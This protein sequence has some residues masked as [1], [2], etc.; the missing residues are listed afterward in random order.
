MSTMSCRLVAN[1]HIHGLY[2]FKN[3]QAFENNDQIPIPYFRKFVKVSSLV[4][5]STMFI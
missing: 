1:T 4:G 5:I 3:T 2:M